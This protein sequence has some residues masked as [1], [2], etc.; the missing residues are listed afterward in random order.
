MN[1]PDCN[2]D[3]V[4]KRGQ[5]NNKQRYECQD[6]D[7]WFSGE[8]NNTNTQK[9]VAQVPF[10]FDIETSIKKAFLFGSGKQYVNADSFEDTSRMICWSGKFVGSP[11]IY[12]DC[13]TPEEAKNK[14][15]RR[16]LKSL[17]NQLSTISI[18]VTHNGVD[19]DNKMINYFFL[20]ERMGLPSKYRNIDTCQLSRRIFRAESNRL[21]Y[22]V[23]DLG[24][25]AGKSS[26]SRQDWIDCYYGDS[27]ALKKMFKYNQNDVMILED[28]LNL[29][30]PYAPNLINMGIFGDVEDSVCPYCGSQNFQENGSFYSPNGKFISYRCECQGLF[31]SKINLLSKNKRKSILSF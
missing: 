19:F 2:S 8:L 7:R 28:L 15:H 13:Q 3:F 23:R 10:I 27:K 5:R 14:D 31:R 21:D 29:I 12:G 4:E 9:V 30:K 24:L 16:I 20:K 6:C 18:A 11:T 26:T 1:C 25:S 17:W 22:L